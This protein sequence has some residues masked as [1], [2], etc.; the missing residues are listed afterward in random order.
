[1]IIASLP[2]IWQACRG[3]SCSWQGFHGEIHNFSRFFLHFSRPKFS[4]RSLNCKLKICTR[5][6]EIN[7]FKFLDRTFWRSI[8]GKALGPFSFCHES[9]HCCSCRSFW[10]LSMI[11]RWSQKW[12]FQAGVFTWNKRKKLNWKIKNF[13]YCTWKSLK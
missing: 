2:W 9:F 3:N 4:H 11:R 7:A 1:M 12:S 5:K 8:Y 13:I 6:Y 10:S